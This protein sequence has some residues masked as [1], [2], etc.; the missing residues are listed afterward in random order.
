MVKSQLSGAFYRRGGRWY[1]KV[2][3]P[4]ESQIKAFPL[5]PKGSKFATR[6]KAVADYIA[7]DIWAEALRKQTSD[8]VACSRIADLIQLYNN[9]AATYYR[10][11]DGSQTQQVKKIELALRYLN[12]FCGTNEPESFGPLRLQGF[13]QELIGRGLSRKYIND[14]IGIIKQVFKW[15]VSKELIAEGAYRALSTVEGLRYS[16]SNAKE[17]EPV[18]PV[19]E[20]Y[21][22]LIVPYTSKVVEAMMKLH[23]LT[24]MR[25]TELCTIRPCDIN[26]TGKVWLYRPVQ[27]KN[28]W[29][30]KERVV[31]IGPQGQNIL[32][33]FLKRNIT[34]Y[35]FTPEESLAVRGKNGKGGKAKE[36]RYN[37]K[38]YRKAVQY[39]IAAYN[40][41]NPE[42][43]IDSF[44]PHQARHTLT[45]KINEA[46]GIEPASAITGNTI[47]AAKIYTENNLK[48][49][50][51]VAEKFG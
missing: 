13:R 36:Q 45:T 19:D 48:L 28:L 14:L 43:Q 23:L 21:I 31:P 30:K 44:T 27:H 37:A 15:G 46:M 40:K 22:Y 34:D 7:R 20:N 41:A 5:T 51:T 11:K 6:D 49:A 16:R 8:I 24:G 35:C 17:T 25:S 3:L 1:W 18:R 10:H 38:S 26:T 47:E 50:I 32:L 42:K 39:A 33:P 29:R 4:G 2:R 12:G 9:H